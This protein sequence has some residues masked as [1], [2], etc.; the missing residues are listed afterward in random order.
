MPLQYELI[1]TQ[2]ALSNENS[3]ARLNAGNTSCR[4]N[5]KPDIPFILVVFYFIHR[6]FKA[7]KLHE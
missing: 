1:A 7:R 4:R 6:P 3:Y 2:E 5:R